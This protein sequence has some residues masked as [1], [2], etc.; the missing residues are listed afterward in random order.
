[1]CP[2]C[3]SLAWE[4][5]ALSGRG[6]LHTW[7]VSVHPTEP[8]ADP[9]IVALVDLDEGVRLVSNLVGVSADAVR[10]DMPLE[11][12]VDEVD[13]VL[14]PQFRPAGGGAR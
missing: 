12:V 13:G 6:S 8:D 11:L 5:Q 1:M 7:I 10:N 3:G 4:I 14:L 2:A 9:R